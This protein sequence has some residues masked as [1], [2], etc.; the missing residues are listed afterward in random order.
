MITAAR[1]N[2]AVK[3]L[4]PPHVAFV[5]ALLSENF[6]IESNSVDYIFSNPVLNSLPPEGKISLLKE[7]N[8]ILRPEGR[9]YLDDVG[10][11]TLFIP[12]IL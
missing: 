7:A 4:K 9:V 6:P 11:S 10:L 3:G 12:K 1:K 8:R 2:A 5:K